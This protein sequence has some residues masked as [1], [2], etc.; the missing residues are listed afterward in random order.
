MIDKAKELKHGT[1]TSSHIVLIPQPSD[2]PCDPYVSCITY[3]LKDRSA[4]H[5]GTSILA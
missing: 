2:D 1:G 4:L 5:P 3:T